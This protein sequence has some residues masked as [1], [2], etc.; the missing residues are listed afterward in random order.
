[1]AQTYK[2]DQAATFASCVLLSVEPKLGF[3]STAQELAGDGTPKWEAQ[4]VA[5]FRQFGRTVNE[6]IKV[7]LVSATNPGDA[8]TPYQPIELIGLE[9]GFMPK[10]AK[11]K[12]TGEKRQVGV[13]IWCRAEGIR[14]IAVAGGH[15]RKISGD[16]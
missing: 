3:K 7:G 5:G 2:V 4:V 9:I 12:E 15:L 10:E 11:D 1:V 8:V 13:N 16:S 6:V 14:P